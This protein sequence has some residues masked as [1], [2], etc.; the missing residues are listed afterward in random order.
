MKPGGWRY[1][2]GMKTL[3]GV[4]TSS[5]DLER[6]VLA[7]RQRGFEP[8]EIQFSYLQQQHQPWEPKGVVAWLRG[9]GFLGDTQARSDNASLMDGTTAGATI[10]SLL[11]VVY[12][13][14]WPM[15]P[16][17]GGTLGILVGGLVGWILDQAIGAPRSRGKIKEKLAPGSCLVVVH[18]ADDNRL[19]NAKEALRTAQVALQ[20]M[21]E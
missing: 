4:L 15:G 13:S 6:A 10:F 9:G 20:G 19:S 11:G 3:V 17:T 14:V 8:A 12:G 18:C 16:I 21:L 5:Y 7:L 1:H 2:K